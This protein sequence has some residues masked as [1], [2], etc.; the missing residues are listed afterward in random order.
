MAD[1]RPDPVA[2]V[3]NNPNAVPPIKDYVAK[4]PESV[5]G[6][7]TPEERAEHGKGMI[8]AVLAGAE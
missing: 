2:E 7:L 3:L 4:H 6:G 8:E 1:E 5:R